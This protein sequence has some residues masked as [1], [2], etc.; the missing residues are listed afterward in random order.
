MNDGLS[1]RQ[2]Q[3]SALGFAGTILS[4]TEKSLEDPGNMLVRDFDSLIMEPNQNVALR[5]QRD[6][7]PGT[8]RGVFESV[9]DEDQKELAQK[10]RVT[11]VANIKKNART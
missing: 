9:I 5:A 8:G 6:A 1:D 7:Q 11:R 3:T 10:R 4:D 2:S